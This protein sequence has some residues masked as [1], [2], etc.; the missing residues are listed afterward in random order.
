[1]A[2]TLYNMLYTST[3]MDH[4]WA[5]RPPSMYNHIGKVWNLWM[6]SH[7]YDASEMFNNMIL[8]KGEMADKNSTDATRIAA[9]TYVMMIM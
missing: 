7:F 2:I 1:M 8:D 3:I 5:T 9:R 6:N 4:N